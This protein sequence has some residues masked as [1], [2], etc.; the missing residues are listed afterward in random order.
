MAVA[1]AWLAGC[2]LPWL[3]TGNPPAGWFGLLWL[4]PLLLAWSPRLRRSHWFALSAVLALAASISE[5]RIVRALDARLPPGLSAQTLELEGRVVG[6]PEADARAWRFDLRVAAAPAGT[7]VERVQLSWFSNAEGTRPQPGEHWRL[8]VRLKRPH[9]AVNPAG[10]DW[11]RLA[12]AQRIDAQGYVQRGERLGVHVFDIDRTRA[13]GSA[14]LAASLGAQ[15]ATALLQALVYGDTRALSVADWALFRDTGTSHLVAISGTHISMVAVAAGALVWWLWR[16]LALLRR[17]PRRQ[18]AAVA[19]WVAA[20][21]YCLLAGFEIPA[22][23]T[24][25]GLTVVAVALLWRRQLSPWATFAAALIVVLAWDPLAPLGA[26]FWLSFGAVAWLVLVFGGRWRR[27]RWWQE[28]F[29]AQWK[30]ALLMLPLTVLLFQQA[31][32]LAPLCNLWAVP[33]VS[34]L[35]VPLGLLGALLLPVPWVGSSLLQCS[36]WLAQLFL[37]GLG[38][39]AALGWLQWSPPPAALA[40]ILLA[41]L[42]AL[43]LILPRG[44]PGR[45]LAPLLWLPLL[46]PR[47][48]LQ[49]AEGRFELT[50]YDIG[51]GL[52]VLVRTRDHALLYDAGPGSGTGQSAAA[53]QILPSLRVVGVSALDQLLLSHGD[54]D[55][56]G[57]APALLTALPVRARRGSAAVPGQQPCLAGQS[58]EWDA[59]R[60]ELLHPTPGLPYLR[61]ESSCV[62]RIVGRDGSALLPGDIGAA[63]EERL[64]ARLPQALPATLLVSPHHGSA[65]SS[66]AAFVEAVRPLWVVHATGHDDRFDFPRAETVARYARIGAQQLDTGSAGAIRLFFDTTQGAWLAERLRSNA[67]RRW[68]EAGSDLERRHDR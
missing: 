68:R 13:Q 3:W 52:S 28:L 26:G 53:T 32:L 12:L 64:L 57:G 22:Q 33:L 36:A 18:V 7:R 24:L 17:W 34:I 54:D 9:G 48:A 2:L 60:F 47:G 55:H 49:L 66:T 1:L 67:P 4:L 14:A 25:L 51:Q 39:S 8:W 23:R 35:V 6:L 65:G 41:V 29:E 21:W 63:I 38:A 40:A 5:W 30:I 43:L 50:V 61:N 19:G 15:P 16:W 31:A 58:W 59:V 27:P 20:L 56:A 42:G 44:V 46:W 11:E 37:D 62:L 10:L 45:W